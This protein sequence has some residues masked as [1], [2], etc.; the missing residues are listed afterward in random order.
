MLT[1][2]IVQHAGRI[3]EVQPEI[4]EL[5][6]S[7]SAHLF[8]R[9]VDVQGVSSPLP[10]LTLQIRISQSWNVVHLSQCTYSPCKLVLRGGDA[11]RLAASH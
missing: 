4:N 11:H 5:L 1:E 2:L 10:N 9:I 7:A 8:P 3:N 6:E